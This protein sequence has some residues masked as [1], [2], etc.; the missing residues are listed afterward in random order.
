MA[1]ARPGNPA[2]PPRK[3]PG[4]R[5][6][7]DAAGQ[8]ERGRRHPRLAASARPLFGFRLDIVAEFVQA[9]TQVNLS[10]S[11]GIAC[12]LIRKPGFGILS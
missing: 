9:V 3:A 5:S 8:L 12:G 7:I 2:P 4:R 10:L 11:R 6:R 1:A